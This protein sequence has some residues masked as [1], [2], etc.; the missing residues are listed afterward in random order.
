MGKKKQKKAPAAKCKTADGISTTP[1]H[2]FISSL[3]KVMFIL[4]SIGGH[5]DANDYNKFLETFSI[6]WHVDIHNDDEIDEIID[7]MEYHEEGRVNLSTSMRNLSVAIT[8][9][10]KTLTKN[11]NHID[12]NDRVMI[13]FEKIESCCSKLSAAISVYK[14]LIEKQRQLIVRLDSFM[15]E[16]LSLTK[17]RC[18]D[19]N[20]SLHVYHA[21]FRYGLIFQTLSEQYLRQLHWENSVLS[22][23]ED[24]LRQGS[25]YSQFDGIVA[26]SNNINVDGGANSVSSDVILH[27]NFRI[28]S[29]GI[30]HCSM[31]QHHLWSSVR[32]ILI[33]DLT[34][35]TVN[36]MKMTREPAE[37]ST[38][39]K[40]D[41]HM[42]N[43]PPKQFQPKM[44]PEVPLSSMVSWNMESV[45]KAR[46]VKSV[47]NKFLNQPIFNLMFDGS[48][49]ESPRDVLGYSSLFTAS[50]RNS[51][52]LFCLLTGSSGSG[53]SHFC[54]E[55]E[56]RIKRLNSNLSWES[57]MVGKFKKT[58]VLSLQDRILETQCLITSN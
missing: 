42:K 41:I 6:E 12:D 29:E 53:K 22:K 8:E 33:K 47:F 40:E 36:K 19:E 16:T 5:F 48:S 56:T 46:S 28:W 24:I 21:F 35:K 50:E 1:P 4:L 49:E 23:T 26:N 30:V 11:E 14:P 39:E 7:A 15:K 43:A 9:F 57:Q 51:D 13:S 18:K 52:A 3:S 44:F 10:S 54:H 20:R 31:L 38:E 17:L 37:R 45:L 58:F 25:L 55:A 27:Q 34:A 32:E 2:A